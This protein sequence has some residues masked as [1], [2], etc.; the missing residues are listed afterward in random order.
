MKNPG[1][2]LPI[3]QTPILDMGILGHLSLFDPSDSEWFEFSD[4]PTMGKV[5]VLFASYYGLK[6]VNHLDG[7]IQIF[8]LFYQMDPNEQRAEENNLWNTPPR[9]FAT[10][11]DLHNFDLAHLV[12]PIYLGF[13]DLAFKGVFQET[14]ERYFNKVMK[15]SI[16]VDYLRPLFEENPFYHPQYLCGRGINTLKSRLIRGKFKETPLADE[17]ITHGVDLPRT[18]MPMAERLEIIEQIRQC[19]TEQKLETFQHNPRDLKTIRFS[20]PLDLQITITAMGSGYVAIRHKVLPKGM[21]YFEGNFPQQEKLDKLILEKFGFTRSYDFRM[22]IGTRIL[23][24][25]EDGLEIIELINQL[26]KELEK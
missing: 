23:L 10:L 15:Q 3:S 14:C 8:N 22:W 17:E 2:A 9:G 26:K 19:A 11:T 12:A 24:N 18:E 20:L 16:A 6:Y 13:G 25:F 4:D 5:A 1:S 7:V 21:N